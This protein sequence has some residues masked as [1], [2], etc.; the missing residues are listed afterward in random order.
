MTKKIK[1][2]TY[3]LGGYDETMPDNNVVETLYY[4]DAELAELAAQ[5]QKAA[6]KAAAQAKLAAL[7]LTSDDLKALGLGAN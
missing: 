6:D 1:S 7:G 2:I 4:T 5:S 3:G